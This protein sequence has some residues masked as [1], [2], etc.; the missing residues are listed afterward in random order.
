[1]KQETIVIKENN[2]HQVDFANLIVSV[3][4]TCGQK[5]EVVVGCP[6]LPNKHSEIRVGD[7]LLFET[8]NDG[9]FEVRA[10]SMDTQN[11][12]MLI[13]HVSPR[14]GIIGGFID[15]DPNNTS[16]SATEL[17]KIAESVK[18]VKADIAKIQ[19]VTPAQIDL[20]ERKLNDIQDASQRLGRKDWVNY[21]AG[22]LTTLCVSAAF[23]PETSKALFKVVNLAFKWLFDNALM[24]LS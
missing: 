14:L 8:P 9:I 6:G 17:E 22:S 4:R 3:R 20:I 12:E 15:D 23:A 13:S 2:S 1:M 16:F 21:V 24:L 19:N 10:L 18:I 11:I 5:S 7:A